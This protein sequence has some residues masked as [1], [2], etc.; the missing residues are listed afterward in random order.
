VD[1][2]LYRVWFSSLLACLPLPI[3]ALAFAVMLAQWSGQERRVSSAVHRR[4]LAVTG[5]GH[6]AVHAI[7]I[8]HF[9]E[10]QYLSLLILNARPDVGHRDL[11]PLAIGATD[12]VASGRSYCS[13]R[14]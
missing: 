8:H 13:D 9:A 12:A 10:P 1:A 3:G 14:P 11:G 5:V 6:A 7:V 2:R 4:F